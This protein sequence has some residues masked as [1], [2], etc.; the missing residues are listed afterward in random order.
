[1]ISY[2]NETQENPPNIFMVT[3]VLIANLNDKNI[4]NDH[5]KHLWVKDIIDEIKEKFTYFSID[6]AENIIQEKYGESKSAIYI[7]AQA[8]NEQHHK[9]R[10]EQYLFLAESDFPKYKPRSYQKIIEGICRGNGKH[11]ALQ[12]EYTTVGEWNVLNSVGDKKH[13]IIDARWPTSNPIMNTNTTIPME[14]CYPIFVDEKLMKA[15]TDG[16]ESVSNREYAFCYN[17]D[18]SLLQ[19]KSKAVFFTEQQNSVHNNQTTIGFCPCW[20][21]GGPSEI[22]DYIWLMCLG[23]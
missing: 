5:V 13:P 12:L 16:E 6:D 17:E 7:F 10:E 11:Y 18:E 14:Y 3:H 8:Y 23:K 1:M 22:A 20:N 2:S 15:S 19:A 9:K 4:I 21:P